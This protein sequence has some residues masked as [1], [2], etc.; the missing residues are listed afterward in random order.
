MD[1]LSFLETI[2]L[3]GALKEE[4]RVMK[5]V[6]MFTEG[7]FLL[8]AIIFAILYIVKR[9]DFIIIYSLFFVFAFLFII[10]IRTYQAVIKKQRREEKY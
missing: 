6:V 2:F 9:Y 1:K 3:K 10:T 8:L 4:T 7:L 5:I